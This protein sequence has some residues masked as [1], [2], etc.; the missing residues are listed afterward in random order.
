MP[1]LTET[2]SSFIAG[3]RWDAIPAAVRAKAR[4][5][6]LDTLGAGLAGS[7]TDESRRVMA[8]VAECQTGDAAGI[9]GTP[10]RASA[11]AAALV[12]GT[13]AHTRELDDFG[14]C[15]H[16]GAVVVP[17]AFAV[18]EQTGA[19][20][21]QLLAA[22][23]AGYEVAARVT[24]GAGGYT[25]HNARGWHSTGTCGSFGA[26]TA[27]AVLLGLDA[28][29]TASAIG[30]SGSF[31]GGLWAFLRDGAM[32]K[33]LHPGKAA[34]T[35]VQAAYLAKHGF[36]GPREVLEA[37][38]GGFF[39]TYA[40]GEAD[41]K[42]VLAGLGEEY[43]IMESGFKPYACCRSVHGALDGVFDIVRTHHLSAT[44]IEA[45]AVRGTEEMTLQ[46]GRPSA[47]NT[48]EAQMSLPYTLAVALLA[49]RASLT[50]YDQHWLADP[51]VHALMPK[52]TMK[53]HPQ[54]K[55]EEYTE[56]EVTTTAGARHTF[57]TTYASGHPRNPLGEADLEAKFS[58]LAGIA[59]SAEAVR[60]V[61]DAVRDLERLDSVARLGRLLTVD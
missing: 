15:G 30:L 13:L 54:P 57:S 4:L 8:G 44:D 45:I 36:T 50:E 14:G 1:T 55:T 18:A 52:I 37:P 21:A 39:S 43:R 2:L 51:R 48:L 27:A 10:Q 24:E 19:S 11:P 38:Y 22:V 42:A 32:S 20:G 53:V 29:D 17:A 34:E 31:T 47:R 5:C 7:R 35:G 61:A 12:N 28:A 59:L 40:P 60:Q 26:A 41:P 56:V 16:S 49:G 33:R 9:W 46:V 6:I 23:V 25:P 3:L 58:L